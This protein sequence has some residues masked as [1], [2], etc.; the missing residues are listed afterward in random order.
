MNATTPPT[1]PMPYINFP[2]PSF[3]LE[4]FERIIDDCT[5]TAAERDVSD[6]Y[7]VLCACAL[8]S[9]RWHPRSRL[10]LYHHIQITGSIQFSKFLQTLLLPKFQYGDFVHRLTIAVDIF[11]PGRFLPTG[12]VFVSLCNRLKN[13][14]RI[15]VVNTP[16]RPHNSFYVCARQ[17][18]TVTTLSLSGF[19]FP[20]VKELVR[21]VLSFP[22]LHTLK[23][24]HNDYDPPGP[25]RLWK[26]HYKTDLKHLTNVQLE[27]VTTEDRPRSSP[28]Y[29]GAFHVVD[30]LA[31]SPTASHLRRIWVAMT[32]ESAHGDRET[33]AVISALLGACGE[34]LEELA[35]AV[36]VTSEVEE[37]WGLDNLSTYMSLSF[38][39]TYTRY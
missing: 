21:F 32:I 26:G 28:N 5:N 20:T 16:F 38:T 29:P 31:A 35:V 2:A 19:T 23:V 18:S 4:I 13:L 6:T 12:V 36:Q 10:R 9:R 39:T 17:F 8:T 34:S 25:S 37:T 15:D 22:L 27:L 14:E 33:A 1:D 24:V 11:K 7:P 30:W 3:P